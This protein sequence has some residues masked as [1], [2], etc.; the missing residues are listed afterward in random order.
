M[1]PADRPVQRPSTARL[2]YIDQNGDIRQAPRSQLHELLRPGDLVIA[3]DAATLPASLHGVHV[4]TGHGIEVRL[5]GKPSLAP[6]DAQRFIA[7]V[8]GAGDYHTRTED[9]PLPP[10]F[11]INDELTLGSLTARVERVLDHPRL[12]SLRFESSPDALWRGL[13]THGRP[14]Q[15]AHMSEP[16][17]LWDV[18]TAIAGVPV[19][20][21]APS[22]GFALDWQMLAAF[23]ARGIEFATLTHAAGIS[24]TGDPA[25]DALLPL[26]EPYRIPV[27]TE[28]A[29]AA[30][31][32]EERRIVAIGT[33]VVRA[34]EHSAATFGSVAAGE[35]VAN[36]R[37]GAQTR[38]RVVDA[39]LSGT[40]EPGTSHYQLLQS[41]ADKA[42]LSR[43]DDAMSSAGYRTHEFGDSVLIERDRR[44]YC[45]E[46]RSKIRA[47]VFPEMQ[48]L[49]ER[50]TPRILRGFALAPTHVVQESNRLS[51]ARRLVCLRD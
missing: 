7:V 11:Q 37:I 27:A 28:Q 3:N 1:I 9:R 51:P 15:Y 25:L 17:A 42:A 10:A 16:L 5:A 6:R 50:R 26:D 12:I 31:L 39:I 18:W 21:E 20:Y 38:L 35:S 23:E 40:H 32:C 36:L 29:I 47:E 22:A 33:T 45:G 8:F 14:I 43:A 19:A 13:A 44:S 34:L 2:L 30:A 4:C 49:V 48:G 24:S 46:A 41:F